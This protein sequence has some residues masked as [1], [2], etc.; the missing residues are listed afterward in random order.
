MKA[1]IQQRLKALAAE[2]LEA[3]EAARE[4]EKLVRSSCPHMKHGL[5]EYTVLVCVIL[6]I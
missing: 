6:R 1:S 2:P 4:I 5:I 3:Y